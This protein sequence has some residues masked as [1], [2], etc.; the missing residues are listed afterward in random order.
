MKLRSCLGCLFLEA[1]GE[2]LFPAHLG[3]WQSS[4]SCGCRT[5]VSILFFCCCCS[6]WLSGGATLSASGLSSLLAHSRSEPAIGGW[7]LLTAIFFSHILFQNS[8]S[9]RSQEQFSASKNS[10]ARVHLDNPISNQIMPISSKNCST[11]GYI[12]CY[13]NAN[14]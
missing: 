1:L 9:D 14:A 5:E 13:G 10:N 4:V 8:L 7:V 2:T 11:E 12:Q 6:S 3:Y